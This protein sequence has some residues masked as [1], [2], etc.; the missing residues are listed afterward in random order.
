MWTGY[1][2]IA[3]FDKLDILYI[4]TCITKTGHYFHT[5][6]TLL[7]LTCIRMYIFT[8]IHTYMYIHTYI[9]IYIR[10][11]IYTYVHIIIIIIDY[12]HYCYNGPYN[13]IY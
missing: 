9:H 4:T 3:K 5:K 1:I 2:T 13:Y 11:Y 12:C 6:T 8:Y 10:T 7:H